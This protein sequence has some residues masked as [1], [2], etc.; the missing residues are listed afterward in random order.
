[1]TGSTDP[2]KKL[3]HWQARKVSIV[4]DPPEQVTADGE[5]LGSTPVNISILPGA[6]HIIVPS[7]A[8]PQGAT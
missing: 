2:A 3:P 8:Q 1:M 7:G 5:V 6:I 4:A